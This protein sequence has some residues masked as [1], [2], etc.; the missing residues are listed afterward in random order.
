MAPRWEF[1]QIRLAWLNWAVRIFRPKTATGRKGTF[2]GLFY[3]KQHQQTR[4]FLWEFGPSL[5]F[6]FASLSLVLSAMQV[7]LTGT[8]DSPWQAFSSV[9]VWFSV[10]CIIL[11]V[12]VFVVMALVAVLVLGLQFSY[13]LSSRRK[14]RS[15]VA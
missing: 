10:V 8:E 6:A 13:A 11:L 2:N 12:S 1:G 5:L 14:R 9:S 4:Q 3:M 7:A 15:V